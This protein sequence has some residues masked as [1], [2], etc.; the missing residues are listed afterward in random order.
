VS[1]LLSLAEIHKL[2]RANGDSAVRRTPIHAL[3]A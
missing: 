1:Y 3:R 2:A